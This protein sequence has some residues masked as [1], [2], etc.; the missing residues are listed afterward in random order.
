MH[1]SD[2]RYERFSK[3]EHSTARELLTQDAET[4]AD[5]LRVLDEEPETF[6]CAFIKETL[7]AL[8][9]M[10]APTHQSHLQVF[11]APRYRRQ[12]I[13]TA[14]VQAA[15]TQLQAGGTRTVSTSSRSGAPAS[16]GFARKLGYAPYYS[17]VYMQRTG[18]FFSQEEAPVR[19]YTDED[20][21]PA[22]SL[23]ATAF[24]EMRVRVGCFP[25]SVVAQ[26]NEGR[27]NAW[28]ADAEDRFVYEFN[29]EIAAYSHLH[30]NEISSV[31]VRSDLQGCGIGREFVKYLC[32]EIYQRGHATVVLCCVVGNEARQLYD[33]LGFQETHIVEY[34]RKPLG[35][36]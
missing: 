20:F 14:M 31:S 13:G 15:E 3:K 21:L 32:N 18:G 22:H 17:L 26:P 33:S 29:G 4:G 24:H 25:D 6:I 30:G 34:M 28:K 10:E 19:L 2:I 36:V 23:Y 11:V 1:L 9:Q 5:L 16:P 7:V 8:A 27:R 12:G 35:S